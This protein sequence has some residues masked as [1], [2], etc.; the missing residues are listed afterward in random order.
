[1]QTQDAP[2][3]FR[4]K[5]P[6]GCTA[7]TNGDATIRVLDTGIDAR[8]PDIGLVVAVEDVMIESILGAA[9]VRGPGNSLRAY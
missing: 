4:E 2:D 7:W 5:L 8:D 3:L 6:F 1:M 9:Q